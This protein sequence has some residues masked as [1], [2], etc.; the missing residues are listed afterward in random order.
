MADGRRLPVGE[1]VLVTDP[2]GIQIGSFHPS[3][4][5]GMIKVDAGELAGRNF[6]GDPIEFEQGKKYYCREV[7]FYIPATEESCDCGFVTIA[8][9]NEPKKEVL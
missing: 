2:Q 8:T 3:R 4:T 5:S 1:Q 7:G 9:T 6:S